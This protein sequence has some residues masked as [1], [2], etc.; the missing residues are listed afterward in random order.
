MSPFSAR[1]RE[2]V[3]ASFPEW[4]PFSSEER[5]RGS[6]PY[7]V[8][9]VSAP[10]EANTALPFRLS[11]WDE[12]ITVD[13]DYYHT[14]FERWNP[15]PGDSRHQAALLYVRDLLSER[16]AV[17]SWWQGRHCKVCGQLEPGESLA[18]PFNVRYTR[19]RVRSWHGSHNVERN[20]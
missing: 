4:Q 17:A 7:F 6:E 3:W 11:T 19:A 5:W 2:E 1:I 20:A 9:T 14:H 16:V 10:S 13:F 12:E 8:V 15:E 18:P